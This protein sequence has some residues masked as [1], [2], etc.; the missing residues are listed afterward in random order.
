MTPY[1]DLH[2]FLFLL[3]PLVALVVLA[4]LGLLRRP[5]VLLVSIA[6]LLF[7]YG[8]PLGLSESTVAGLGQLGFLVVYATGSVAIVLAYAAI[9][10]RHA[11]GA[12]FYAAIALAL[13][14]L[15]ILKVYPLLRGFPLAAPTSTPTKVTVLPGVPAVT[16]GF[17]DTFGFLGISS[18]TLRVI[19]SITRRVM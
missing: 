7:Q 18:M 19:A 5:V 16:T 15:V 11:G 2:Y 17:F 9:R 4:L 3:Y 10:R 14:P 12:P 6:M 13:A 1:V 8:D